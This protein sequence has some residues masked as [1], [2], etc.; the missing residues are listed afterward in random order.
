MHLASSVLHLASKMH[1][2]PLTLGH[3]RVT[4]LNSATKKEMRQLLAPGLGLGAECIALHFS[5]PRQ[6]CVPISAFL[7]VYYNC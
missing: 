2:A 5:Q 1:H 6:E 3:A 7:P 4:P